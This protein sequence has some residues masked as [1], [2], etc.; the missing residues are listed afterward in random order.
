MD[1]SSAFPGCCKPAPKP[2]AKSTRDL[3]TIAEALDKIAG[4]TPNN[5]GSAVYAYNTFYA[6][7]SDSATHAGLAAVRRFVEIRHGRVR[8]ADSPPPL[9]TRLRHLIVAGLLGDLAWQVFI[10]FG[11]PTDDL[12]ATGVRWATPKP[13]P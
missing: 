6:P 5:R 7:L 12:E 13:K 9:T 3:A 10:A 4:L 11:I 2:K 8:M 1:H